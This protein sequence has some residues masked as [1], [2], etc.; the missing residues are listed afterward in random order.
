M[1]K[2]FFYDYGFGVIFGARVSL[3]ITSVEIKGS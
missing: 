1:L 3:Y 2:K